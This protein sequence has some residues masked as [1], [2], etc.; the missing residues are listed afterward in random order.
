MR[1]C[2]VITSA[3]LVLVGCASEPG[4]EPD[5]EE[6]IKGSVDP[7]VESI[8]RSVSALLGESQRFSFHAEITYDE[9]ETL[10]DAPT[11][12]KVQYSA[13]T[14][15]RVSR[16]EKLRVSYRSDREQREFFLD[17]STATMLAPDENIYATL[18][19]PGTIDDALDALWEGAGVAPPLSDLVYRDPYARLAPNIINGTYVGLHDIDGAPCHHILLTQETM[20]WQL[21]VDAGDRPLPRRIVIT[22]RELPQAPVFAADLGGWNFDPSF[23]PETFGFEPPEGA[24][25]VDA[26]VTPIAGNTHE[27]GP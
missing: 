17:G 5:P 21:W 18:A 24:I 8:L 9:I 20:D 22:Y 3:L 11:G 16:P 10:A 14:N 15:F 23:S 19:A 7:R 13:R 2:T 12:T 1:H 25:E 27:E 6:V 4:T 26:V